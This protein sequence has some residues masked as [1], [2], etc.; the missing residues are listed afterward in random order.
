MSVF[1]ERLRNARVEKGIKQAEIAEKLGVSVQSYS[2]YENGRE[3]NYDILLKIAKILDVEASY[4]IGESDYKHS[5]NSDICSVTGLSER[6]VEILACWNREKTESSFI[7]NEEKGT[8]TEIKGLNGEPIKFADI[9]SWLIEERCVFTEMIEY[10]NENAFYKFVEGYAAFF[11]PKKDER[12]LTENIDT[13]IADAEK[14]LLGYISTEFIN[15][16][17][18]IQKNNFSPSV[19]GMKD[20]LNDTTIRHPRKGRFINSGDSNADD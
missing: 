15:T 6:A 19:E 16:L 8:V 13:T 14:M 11:A 18:D 5:L 17:K 20:Y 12:A 10:V 9:V 3:P 2:A 4:L 1:S 7:E